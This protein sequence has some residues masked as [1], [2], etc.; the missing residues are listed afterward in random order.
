MILTLQ[1][2][3]VQTIK[4]GDVLYSQGTNGD[5]LYIVDSGDVEA[6]LINNGT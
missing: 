6:F 3:P 4:N 5:V 2:N 1:N